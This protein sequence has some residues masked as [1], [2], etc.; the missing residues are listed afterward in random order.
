MKTIA[1]KKTLKVE[2]TTSPC[3]SN[4]FTERVKALRE[5]GFKVYVSHKR[6][7]LDSTPLRKKRAP[8]SLKDYKTT[9]IL[10]PKRNAT[11]Y[12]AK[13]A[14][15]SGFTKLYER[16]GATFVTL[17]APDGKVY[18]GVSYC[19]PIDRFVK[20]QGLNKA[21][22]QAISYYTRGL[23]KTKVAKLSKESVE[24]ILKQKRNGK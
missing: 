22:G 19:N 15:M 2:R 8:F 9:H 10:V 17:T 12:D 5:Q 4:T 18:E 20:T 1:K 16:G 6:I 24:T 3:S 7:Y 13:E 23:D 11:L 21:L 14:A